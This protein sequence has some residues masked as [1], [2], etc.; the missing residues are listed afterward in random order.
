MGRAQRVKGRPSGSGQLAQWLGK[1][2]QAKGAAM[3]LS[4]GVLLHRQA[5]VRAARAK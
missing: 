5:G 4:L 3:S 2:F 1:Q